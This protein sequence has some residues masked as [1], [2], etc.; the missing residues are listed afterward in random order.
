LTLATRNRCLANARNPITTALIVCAVVVFSSHAY[1][2]ASDTSAP[3]GD[4]A[5]GN[6]AEARKLMS[7]MEGVYKHRFSNS[8][9]SGDKFQSED[10]LEFVPVSGLAA[11]VKA[12]LEFSNG[13]VCDLA[14]IAEF[15]KTAAFI[16]QDEDVADQAGQCRLSIRKN[17]DQVSF[18]DPDGNCEKFCGVRGSFDGATFAMSARRKIGYMPIILKSKEYL[19]SLQSY[20]QR[21]GTDK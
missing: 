2:Q 19:D 6:P 9:A 17:A 8:D 21:R 18:E 7:E 16:Y 20:R 4:S 14:G 3:Q 5:A 1:S 11:Y 13:H 10:I 15:K 12:H